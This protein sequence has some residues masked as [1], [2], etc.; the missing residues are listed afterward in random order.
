MTDARRPL[1]AWYDDAKLGIFI[2]WCPAAVPGFAPPRR[3]E[4]DGDE[5][6]ERFFR[7]NPCAETYW[8]TM[9]VPGSETAAFHAE[10]YGELPYDAFV[11]EFRA[12]LD[13]WDPEAWVD[14]FVQAG[15]RY[16]VFFAKLEDGFT[17]W[18]SEHPNPYKKRWSAERDVVGELAAA[19]RRKG[20]RF[21]IAYSGGMDFTFGGLPITDLASLEAA[22]PQTEEFATYVKAHWRE[23]IDRY[24]PDVI[25]DDWGYPASADPAGLIRWYWER[26]P[27]GVS[28]NRFAGFRSPEIRTMGDINTPEYATD[29]S[30]Y[31]TVRERKWEACRGIG[32]S[33]G[34]NRAETDETYAPSSQL[35]RDLVEITAR[36]GNFLLNVGPTAPGEIPWEQSRRLTEIGLWLRANGPAVYG[37]REWAIPVATNRDGEQVYFTAT[38]GAVHAIIPGDWHPERTTVELPVAIDDGATVE[39]LG[40]RAPVD[41]SSDRASV[42]VTLPGPTTTPALALR[43]TPPDAVRPVEDIACSLGGGDAEGL[44]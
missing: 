42:R 12:G 21:G 14:L 13:R 15:A 35:I 22:H 6:F 32:A 43:L 5:N 2:H 16:I 26:V 9:L 24:E 20:L 39:V 1:P 28:N 37:T 40:L 30:G 18:P 38:D 41:H 10:R 3:P 4:R 44:I 34:Y 33:W 17:L 27:E 7:E 8:N 19:A 25:W 11:E 31:S 29:F 23:L 36:G